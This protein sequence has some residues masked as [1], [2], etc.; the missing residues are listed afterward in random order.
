MKI[1]ELI[2]LL[3]S[4]EPDANVRFSVANDHPSADSEERWFAE[5]G[6]HD[7]FGDSGEVT[8]CLVVVSNMESEQAA[9][10]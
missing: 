6:V 2:R 4:Y 3:K 5:D 7:S 1:K 8:L 9:D 10:Q